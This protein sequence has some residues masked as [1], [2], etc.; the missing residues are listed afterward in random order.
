M[1]LKVISRIIQI[2]DRG[3][4]LNILQDLHNTSYHTKVESNNFSILFV[5]NNSYL[6]T[7]L[8]PCST[9]LGRSSA[10]SSPNVWNFSP[11]S[12]KTT[13]LTQSFPQ[14]YLLLSLFLVI[15]CIIDDMLPDIAYVFQIWSTL[16]GFEELAGGLE[17]IR[18]GEYFE[19]YHWETLC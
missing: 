6:K 16:A 12:T 17:Q 10:S 7:G 8:P 5:Q 9:F 1:M 4:V 2:K 18:N 19:L 3:Q 13:E 15:S 14:G 11:F